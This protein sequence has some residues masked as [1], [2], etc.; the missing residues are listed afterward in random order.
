MENNQKP[1]SIIQHFNSIWFAS[2]MGTAVIPLALSFINH[3][4]KMPF[5]FFFFYLAVAVFIAALIPWTLKFFL[6]PQNVKKDLNHPIAAHFFPTMPIALIILALDILKFPAL[7]FNTPASQQIALVLWML[8]VVG[9]YGFGF[10]VIMHIFRDSGIDLAHANFGWYIPPVSKLLIPVAGFELVAL[11]PDQSELIFGISTASLGVGFFIFLF[12]GAAVYHRYIYHELPMSRFAA[13]FFIGIAP[14]AIIAVILFKMKHLFAHHPILG[15]TA[16]LFSPIANI[17]ILMNWGLAFWWFI[18]AIL[19]LIYYAK[20]IELPYAM[21]WWAWTFPSGALA[22]A[23][24]V[25]WK[26][27]QF[28]Y[29]MY[30]YGLVVIFLLVAWSVVFIRTIK[31][32]ISGQVF[33][34]TH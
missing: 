30:I 29:F 11:F 7:V 14:T 28:N 13:T 21:S 24:G 15:I 32:V 26:S 18:M 20:K 2:V 17:G 10:V 6:Y 34:P 9:I 8:G 12:V 25:V 3:P 19:V 4:A 16:D 1:P 23:T 22:V 33:K 31:G 5:V 27:T